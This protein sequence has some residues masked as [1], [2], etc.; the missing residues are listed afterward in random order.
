M[1]L[2]AWNRH[3]FFLPVALA[4]TGY[5]RKEACAFL[6][7][8]NFSSGFKLI[9]HMVFMVQLI[10]LF[11]ECSYS[12]KANIHGLQSFD[13]ESWIAVPRQCTLPLPCTWSWCLCCIVQC[14]CTEH[15]ALLPLF[16]T[17]KLTGI[18]M[19][20]DRVLFSCLTS[21]GKLNLSWGGSVLTLFYLP[22]R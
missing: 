17:L 16:S 4:I 7:W 15:V 5:Q 12:C 3:I 10:L 13:F 11:H 6:S 9:N 2:K 14:Q 8:C 21:E 22:E 18:W 20:R 19:L 1:L